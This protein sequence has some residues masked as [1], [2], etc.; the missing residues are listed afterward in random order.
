MKLTNKLTA[1]CIYENLKIDEGE[2]IASYFQR[3]DLVANEDRNQGGTL[4]NEDI[5]E[6]IL[7]TLLES[8]ND[9]DL[10]IEEVYDPKKFTKEQLFGTLTAFEMRKFGKK[11]EKIE[12]TFKATK[13][14][15]DTNSDDSVELEENFTKKLKRDTSKYKGMLPFKWFSCGNIRHYAS[16]FLNRATHKKNMD[17]KHNKD[18]EYKKLYYVKEDVGI[19]NDESNFEGDDSEYLFLALENKSVC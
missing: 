18:K 15:D 17:N 3:V 16:R 10:F 8:Y 7:M 9:K 1:K 6:N 11:E 4:E 12:S 5:I 14:E 2:D 19:S 13:I